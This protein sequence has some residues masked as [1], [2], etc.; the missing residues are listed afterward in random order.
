MLKSDTLFLSTKDLYQTFSSHVVISD[1]YREKDSIKSLKYLKDALKI[2]K[3][4]EEQGMS[5][6]VWIERLY[7]S[8]IP[9]VDMSN[10]S[11]KVMVNELVLAHEKNT[12]NIKTNIENI[13]Q[14][15][16]KRK[17]VKKENKMKEKEK[18]MKEKRERNNKIK[19]ISI[20]V[21]IIVIIIVSKKLKNDKKRREEDNRKKRELEEE[22][23]KIEEYKGLSECVRRCAASSALRSRSPHRHCP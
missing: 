4:L 6:Y 12:T 15:I 23:K 16:S 10:D 3:D 11:L 20:L 22:K 13:S 1:R 21:G 19:A 7:K 9:R 5:P 8:F 18:E 2:K 14:E 17:E